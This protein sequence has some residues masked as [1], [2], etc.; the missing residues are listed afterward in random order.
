MEKIHTI[1]SLPEE[2]E[3]KLQGKIF[4]AKS[5]C[6]TISEEKEIASKLIEATIIQKDRELTDEELEYYYS[7]R[8]RLDEAS[9]LV[10]TLLEAKRV[11]EILGFDH[12]SL[13]DTLSHENSHTNKAM[14]LGANFGGYNFLLIKDTDGG[15][16]ITPSATTSI[17]EDWSKEKKE[18]AMTKIISAPDEYGNKM[19]EMDKMELKIRYGK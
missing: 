13:I 3:N 6:L 17:P 9:I 10:E 19:S 16:L 7:Y 18:E 15:Y 4:H 8:E 2:V 14:Q 12:D 5:Y 1:T 11:M